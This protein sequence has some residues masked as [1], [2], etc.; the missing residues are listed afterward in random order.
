MKIHNR[1][2]RM[3]SGVAFLIV[4]LM[5]IP[6]TAYAAGS[7]AGEYDTTRSAVSQ[8]AYGED[9]DSASAENQG[10][11]NGKAV[12]ATGTG[13]DAAAGTN[14]GTGAD[15]DTGAGAGSSTDADADS[16]SDAKSTDGAKATDDAKAKSKDAAQKSA[17]GKNASKAENVSA[18]SSDT[19]GNTAGTSS[20]SIANPRVQ[21]GHEDGVEVASWD[22]L[23]NALTDTAISKIYF[24]GDI[25]RTGS[26]D[27]VNDLPK[28]TRNIEINGEG[29]TL[30]FS[31]VNRRGFELGEATPAA[32][33][34]K[35]SN[36]TVKR[37]TTTGYFIQTTVIDTNERQPSPTTGG[38]NIFVDNVSAKGTTN[39]GFVYAGDSEVHFYGKI[40]WIASADITLVMARGTTFE[41]G[42]DIHF[43]TGNRSV[44]FVDSSAQN[45]ADA[46]NTLLY[47]DAKGGAKVNLK[48]AGRQ[49]VNVNFENGTISPIRFAMSGAGTEVRAIGRTTERNEYT[50]VFRAVG[51]SGGFEVTDGA[52]VT[53][54][55]L[56][57]QRAMIQKINV[58]TFNVSGEGT[59]LNLK[60]A[61]GDD[62][63]ATLH[64]YQ[65]GNQIFNVSDHGKL[66]VI[67]IQENGANA[68]AVRMYGSNNKF[69]VSSG[70]QVYIENQGNGIPTNPDDHNGQNKGIEF[71]NGDNQA[72]NI[73]GSNSSVQIIAKNGAAVYGRDNF[74]FTISDGAI[75]IAEGRTKDNNDSYGV[76]AGRNNFNFTMNNPL[77]YDIRN[78]RP[79]GGR[80]IT[81]GNDKGVFTSINSDLA[82]WS[83]TQPLNSDPTK[84]WSLFD[85]I[86]TGTSYKQI[87][88]TNVPT[89]FNTKSFGTVGISAY[90]RMS[91]NNATPNITDILPAT[92]ADKYI[93]A[94]GTIPEGLN[95]AGRP[96]WTDEVHGIFE[97][98]HAD[99]SVS[100]CPASSIQSEMVYG[101][102]KH[103]VLHFAAPDFLQTGDKIKIVSAWRGG[104]D[105]TSPRVHMSTPDKLTNEVASVADATPASPVIITTQKLYA[106]TTEI[107]G[108]ATPD[109]TATPYNKDSGAR[110]YAA[111]TKHGTSTPI[112]I[113]DTALAGNTPFY[114][115]VNPDGTWV[116]EIPDNMK[117]LLRKAG[118]DVIQIVLEDAVKPDNESPRKHLANPLV[119]TPYRDAT[120][121]QATKI[122]TSE[123]RFEIK[124]DDAII[125]RTS[126][127]A[128]IASMNTTDVA[129]V[130]TLN[131]RISETT[132]PADNGK[133]GVKL[134][135]DGGFKAANG[136]DGSYK[137]TFAV[138]SNTPSD[139]DLYQATA[140]L[141]VLDNDNVSE[142][143]D[144]II[145][146]N[147]ITI[148]AMNLQKILAKPSDEEDA[149]LIA[150][151]NARGFL[152][153][154]GPTPKHTLSVGNVNVDT[155][156]AQATAGTY[157]LKFG[158]KDD[159]S[160]KLTVKIHVIEGSYPVFDIHSP[161]ELQ[162]GDSY[163]LGQNNA[164]GTARVTAKE[165]ATD[166]TD[167]STSITSSGAVDTSKKGIYTVEYKATNSDGNTKTEKQV[168]VVNDG[169]YVIISEAGIGY[170]LQAQ[171]YVKNAPVSATDVLNATICLDS[172][173]QAWYIDE[174]GSH[175]TAASVKSVDS[176]YSAGKGAGIYEHVI[177]IENHKLAT[178]TVQAVVVGDGVIVPGKDDHDTEYSLNAHAASVSLYDARF[179][180]SSAAMSTTSLT[181]I[182]G[183]KGFRL[184][185]SAVGVALEIE[186]NGVQNAT[187]TWPVTF[188]IASVPSIKITVNITVGES[189]PPILKVQSPREFTVPTGTAETL[190]A[191]QILAS[192]C[193]VDIEDGV[194][195]EDKITIAAINGQAYGPANTINVSPDAVGIY[196]V[197]YKVTDSHGKSATAIGIIVVNDGR[198]VIDK[199]ILEA[200]PFVTKVTD[201]ITPAGTGA[202][203][204]ELLHKSEAT[205][206]NGTTGKKR[207]EAKYTTVAGTDIGDYKAAV[208]PDGE[209]KITVSGLTLDPEAYTL[210]KPITGKV[211]AGDVLEGGEDKNGHHYDIWANHVILSQASATAIYDGTYEGMTSEAALV[212]VSKAQAAKELG[213]DL[214]AADVKVVS[215]ELAKTGAEVAA[216]RYLVTFAAKDAPNATV[217]IAL[218]V[219]RSIPPYPPQLKVETPIEIAYDKN[220]TNAINVSNYTSTVSALGVIGT[221][222]GIA[223]QDYNVNDGSILNENSPRD[224]GGII[225]DGQHDVVVDGLNSYIVYSY[226]AI[227]TIA[228]GNA[229]PMTISYKI[230]KNGTPV[231]AVYAS[232]PGVYKVDYVVTDNND[233]TDEQSRVI[234]INDGSYTVD[235][236]VIIGAK[237]FLISK[238]AVNTAALNSQ[239]LN[240]S[241][242]TA[243]DHCGNEIHRED[244]GAQ[245]AGLYVSALGG[246][247]DNVGLYHP[248]VKVRGVDKTRT[249]AAR[250]FDEDSVDE[251]KTSDSAITTGTA[252]NGTQYSLLAYS[253]R[254]NIVQAKALLTKAKAQTTPPITNSI[255]G[256]YTT[257]V[258]RNAAVKAYI[259]DKNLSEEGTP[260]LV[261]DGG[262][263]LISDADIAEGL[264]F[265]VTF[266]VREETPDNPANY[267]TVTM[268][269]DNLD[270]PVL[271]VPAIR[272][273]SVGDTLG[274]KQILELGDEA[275]RAPEAHDVQDGNLTSKITIEAIDG[276]P[277]AADNNSI[278]TAKVGL[279]TVSYAVTD[280]DYNTVSKTGFILVNDGIYIVDPPGGDGDPD[281]ATYLIKA[282]NFVKTLDEVKSDF[283]TLT[284][285]PAA[286]QKYASVEAWKITANASQT[287]VTTQA[288]D[289]ADLTFDDAGFTKVA[290]VY[291]PITVQIKNHTDKY[292][293]VTG[294]VLGLEDGDDPDTNEELKV[295]TD[296]NINEK[297]VNTGEFA[298][299]GSPVDGDGSIGVA[300]DGGVTLDPDTY[301]NATTYHLAARDFAVRTS[302]AKAATT[303]QKN[304]NN[305]ILAEAKAE[306]VKLLPTS[307]SRNLKINIVT[308]GG[309]YAGQSAVGG[310]VPG[311]YKILLSVD[312]APDV[313]I[314]LTGYATKG[315]APTITANGTLEFT[316][317]TRTALLTEAYL[318][319]G[320]TASDAEDG[321][322]TSKVKID[323]IK[324]EN[325]KDLGKKVRE[326]QVGVYQVTYGVTD[327]DGNHV[328]TTRAL[329]V[330]DGRFIVGPNDPSTDDEDKIILSAKSFVINHAD[331][332]GTDTEIVTQSLAAAWDYEGKKVPEISLV[333]PIARGENNN[334]HQYGELDGTATAAGIFPITI[335]AVKTASGNEVSRVEK[336]ITARVVSKAIVSTP[337]A[338]SKYQVGANDFS[339]TLT[340]A[341]KI[342][343][344]TYKIDSTSP[345]LTSKAA[346]V[347]LAE[348]EA[349]QI[350]PDYT[351]TNVIVD[352]T[353]FKA[354]LTDD[355]DY[356]TVTF[357]CE[358][359]PN[360]KVTVKVRVTLGN[361]PVITAAGIVA[362]STTALGT[363]IADTV[364][365]KDVSAWDIEDHNLT[366][367]ITYKAFDLQGNAIA[368]I[369]TSVAGI[370]KVAYTVTDEDGNQATATRA[371]V[372][373]D[374]RYAVNPPGA[375]GEGFILGAKDYVI[376]Q[377]E[378]IGTDEEVLTNSYAVAYDAAGK[379]LTNAVGVSKYHDDA[380]TGMSYDDARSGNITSGAYN[381]DVSLYD[382]NDK[383]ITTK[384]ITAYVEN[385]DENGSINPDS[386]Y[387][388]AANNV[389]IPIAAAR[390][391]SSEADAKAMILARS[392]Y[393]VRHLV[394]PEGHTHTPAELDAS[395]AYLGASFTDKIAAN[396][397]SA[398]A[399]GDTWL[400]TLY[401]N[402][403]ETATVQIRVTILDDRPTLTVKSPIIVSLGA[404]YNP[405]W[406]VNA[407]DV[408]DSAK[409]PATKP[410]ITYAPVAGSSNVPLDDIV[411]TADGAYGVATKAGVYLLNYTATDSDGNAVSAKRMVIVDDGNNNYQNADGDE[412]T[413]DSYPGVPTDGAI[414]AAVDPNNPNNPKIHYVIGG[415]DFTIN[416][417]AVESTAADRRAQ[418]LA[419]SEAFA[420]DVK[421]LEANTA[422]GVPVKVNNLKG[423]N[424]TNDYITHTYKPIIQLA[425]SEYVTTQIVAT[426]T[427]KQQGQAP[428]APSLTI[429]TPLVIDAQQTNPA[430]VSEQALLSNVTAVGV[431]A[432]TSALVPDG[433]DE[434]DWP[435]YGATPT[436]NPDGE[437]VAGTFS[438]VD[439]VVY[440]YGAIT[441]SAVDPVNHLGVLN[442]AV[443]NGPIYTSQPGV[444]QVS[445]EA[446]DL[447]GVAVSALGS[448]L[449]SDGS[450]LYEDGYFVGGKS[451]LISKAAVEEAETAALGGATDTV[452]KQILA[453]SGAVG[454]D[455]NGNVMTPKVKNLDGYHAA[456]GV[457]EPVLGI[458]ENTKPE[459]KIHARVYD[460]GGTGF[461][462]NHYSIVGYDYKLN[463]TLAT[464]LSD[465]KDAAVAATGQLGPY[466]GTAYEASVLKD[467]KVQTYLR[468]FGMAASGTAVLVS[469]GG[470]TWNASS[471]PFESYPL[472]FAVKEEP[473]T[474]ITITV[475]F[476]DGEPPVLTVPA[477]KTYTT[478]AIID[479]TQLF[480]N[481]TAYDKEDGST[482]KDKIT[483]A[484][485]TDLA[486][487]RIFAAGETI[488]TTAAGLYSVTYTVMDHDFNQVTKSGLILVNDDTYIVDPPGGDGDDND[489]TYVVK[490][491]GFIKK[492]ADVSDD[493]RGGMTTAQAIA[494]YAGI[495]AWSVST[496]G[497]VTNE[498]AIIQ[499]DGGF[500]VTEG[501]YNIKV[502]IAG[503]TDNA[504][505][506]LGVLHDDTVSDDKD[507]HENGADATYRIGAKDINL[508]YAD[509]VTLSKKSRT[510]YLAEL[511][512]LAKAHAEKI[513][514][515]VVVTDFVVSG[516][517]FDT[518]IQDGDNITPGGVYNITFKMKSPHE[519]VNVTVRINVAQGLSLPILTASGILEE[520]YDAEN[521]HALTD[522]SILDRHVKAYDADDAL[523]GETPKIT[524][525]AFNLSG[526]AIAKIYTSEAGIYTIRYQAKDLDGNKAY[527][528]RTAIIN[529]GTITI[530]TPPSGGNVDRYLVKAAGFI[531]NA[532]D[533]ATAIHAT[534]TDAAILNY[535]Q[536]AAYEI[537]D[538]AVTV[539][540]AAVLN[541]DGF[542]AAEGDY[543]IQIG[544]A[545]IAGQSRNILGVVL[546]A[547][548]NN[549][550]AT[551]TIGAK[552]VELSYVD[553]RAIASEASITSTSALKARAG[554]HGYK[555]VTD[556]S[557]LPA[558]DIVVSA[559]NFKARPGTYDITFA[560]KD[561]PSV[562]VTV[563]ITVL[564][565]NGKPT[566]NAPG[567]IS[568]AA[569]S[570]PAS[571][572]AIA[573][574][575]I[576]K[577]V[578]ATDIE[579]IDLGFDTTGTVT[580]QAFRVSGTAVTPIADNKIYTSE[581]GIYLIR[582]A[583]H[584]HDGN[585]AYATRAAVVNDDTY[586][587]DEPGGAGDGSDSN[588]YFIHADGFIKTLAEVGGAGA[589]LS[590]AQLLAFTKAQA[591]SLSPD[592]V[593]AAVVPA[594]ISAE[595]VT[596]AGNIYTAA[597]GDYNIVLAMAAD[598]TDHMTTVLGVLLDDDAADDNI[599]PDG[600]HDTTSPGAITEG[601]IGAGEDP[602]P[603]SAA[604]KYTLGAKNISLSF[605]DAVNLYKSTTKNAQL[606]A[607][608]EA[609][610]Y[611]F[612]TKLTK[613]SDSEYRIKD[614]NFVNKPGLYTIT[615]EVVSM[616]EVNVTVTIRVAEGGHLPT[617]TAD[618]FISEAAVKTGGRALTDA[619]LLVSVEA[620]DVDD[621]LLGTTPTIRY[622]IKDEFGVNKIDQHIYTSEAGMYAVKYTAT[623]TDGHKA[624]VS[625]P[626]LINNGTFTV[627]P[628]G[629]DGDGTDRNTYFIKA[630]GFI[631]KLSDISGTAISDADLLGANYTDTSAWSL[632]ENGVF[633]RINDN[634]MLAVT[635]RGG[636]TAAEGDYTIGVGINGHT[637][638]TR[639]VLG[640]VTNDDKTDDNIGP[641][642]NPT[643]S[644]ISYTIG[645]NDAT[646]SFASAV[647]IYNSS[648]TVKKEQLA[649]LTKSHGYKL[650]GYLS[651]LVYG[652][653]Y[654]LKDTT[655]Q[656]KPGTYTATFEVVDVPEVN[657]TVVITVEAGANLPVIT[658]SGIVSAAAVVAGTPISDATIRAN[659]TA[660]DVEDA[661]IGKTPT[662]TYQAYNLSGD[663]VNAI[664]TTTAGIYTIK[665]QA[666]D[667]DG[668]IAIASRT[669][670]V[671]DGTVVVVD[672]PAGGED[673]DAY[674]VEAHDFVKQMKDVSAKITATSKNES[675]LSF[676]NAK[677]YAISRGAI[678]PT[679]PAVIADAGFDAVGSTIF[680]PIKIGIAGVA[681]PVRSITGVIF[682]DDAA[683]DNIGPDGDY[684]STD[685][686]VPTEGV[687]DPDN[688]ASAIK[689]TIGANDIELSYIQARQLAADPATHAALKKLAGVHGVKFT[690]SVALLAPTDDI[691]VV[692]T[693]FAPNEGNYHITFA[694]KDEPTVN[695]TVRIMVQPGAGL[696]ELYAPG[697]ISRS[698]VSTGGAALTDDEIKVS[699]NAIDIED[700]NSGFDT[701][702]T[703]TYQAFRVS[704]TSLKPV[705]H[706]YT[707]ESGIYLIR[708]AAHDGDAAAHYAYAT[709]AAIVNDG[710]YLIDEPPFPG[711]PDQ[712]TYF[713]NA[714]GFIEKLAALG[715]AGASVT[716]AKL[717]EL[718]H[719][720][721]YALSPLGVYTDANG[722][723]V[724]S[725]RDG[726]HTAAA[727]EYDIKVSIAG[728]TKSKTVLG[729]ILGDSATDDNIGPD[730]DNDSTDPS[731]PTEGAIEADPTDSAI[732]YTIGASDATIPFASAVAIARGTNAQQKAGLATL[733]KVHGYKFESDLSKLIYNTDYEVVSTDFAALR[734]VYHVTFAV[735]A[736]PSI[737]VTVRVTV[738]SGTSTP[739]I[740]VG[741]IITENAVA[742][743]GAKIGKTALM[744]GVSSY[745]A[746]D[747]SVG[748]EPAITYQAY[749]AD[750]NAID[751]IYTSQ[752]GIYSVKYVATDLDGNTASAIRAVL[753]NDGTYVVDPPGGDGADDGNTYIIHA[754][755]FIKDAEEVK[756][757]IWDN[758]LGVSGTILSY[759]NP[760]AW[761]VTTS[762]ITKADAA[763]AVISDGG[764]HEVEGV[765]QIQVGIQGHT[766]AAKSVLGVV[767]DA[768]GIYDDNLSG[769]DDNSTVGSIPSEEIETDPMDSGITYR[770]GASDVTLSLAS[771]QALAT[772][773]VKN[774]N[775]QIKKLA[776]SYGYK[777]SPALSAEPY[778]V[779]ATSFHAGDSSFRVTP[780]AVHYVTFA[781][782]SQPSINVS[783]KITIATGTNLPV[784]TGGAI[785]SE[786][787]VKPGSQVDL[788]QGVSTYDADDALVGKPNPP[789]TYQAYDA[790]GVSIPAI[791]TS[792]AGVYSV[793][794]IT[795][796]LD[797]NTASTVRGVVINDGN[798]VIDEPGG[799][800]DDGSGNTYVI[801]AAG[802]IKSADDVAAGIAS[803]GKDNA[804]LSYVNP[805][806][807]AMSANGI[808]P[809]NSAIAVISDGGFDS[810]EGAYN[811]TVGLVGH[812][813]AAKTVLGVV[814]DSESVYDDN[815]GGPDNN[816]TVGEV[817]SEDIETDPTGSGITY[818]IGASDVT[819]SL[820]SAQALATGSVKNF[821]TQIKKLAKSYGY[822]FSPALS[823]EPYQVAATSFH[824]GD[825]SFRVTPGVVHYVTFAL[826]S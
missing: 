236:D 753:I 617:I 564:A 354:K 269:I 687:I 138:V 415:H 455:E 135:T 404:L 583:A 101:E 517:S 16:D 704:G 670:I 693:T 48:S 1:F 254:L 32:M 558:D 19:G 587:I 562:N 430:Q 613:L 450:I 632:T 115:T 470:F 174:D 773:S 441:T 662:I 755:G 464:K 255:T 219:G 223:G 595:K 716:D 176:E 352:S 698:A 262:F 612:D 155:H 667:A 171:S 598:H 733:T 720:D 154:E 58:G 45:D 274:T 183:A 179:L 303:S 288:V 589:T 505:A 677:A 99:N 411:T 603:T 277:F 249:I 299:D 275:G 191:A 26:N 325:G 802:F 466:E 327:D 646:I 661:L 619:E 666:T 531:K 402:E 23:K 129:I 31:N 715:G 752:A 740:T 510:D 634:S 495:A 741:G 762:S 656:E 131:A 616:P 355:D 59:E 178:K 322:L 665:Y 213:A 381:I 235:K 349:W 74:D 434:E 210:K 70:G 13:S 456:E 756:T 163:T 541:T 3:K 647:A 641:D 623:D 2:Q 668:N 185:G 492:V 774:F 403:E 405:I 724:V 75:F 41:A 189:T 406:G 568:V 30:D 296:D 658:A 588:T 433:V 212:S 293:E 137:M 199:D 509:A 7:A 113:T 513:T 169:S 357:A 205:V 532:A 471:S 345:E 407:T 297:N 424:R 193:A 141:R 525:Q 118:G 202:A 769:E 707:S 476:G 359:D 316:A 6:Q 335:A 208:S 346:L 527:A 119:D 440:T 817:L 709:R 109:P 409:N 680:R 267:V 503:H 453:K 53:L 261:S 93:R 386:T 596:G 9:A 117:A 91:G 576:K 628:P 673:V 761:A 111:I 286:V 436:A 283:G 749:D 692:S 807:W 39:G 800:G 384:A 535:A 168:V 801:H 717:L 62:N 298:P 35:I 12:A 461:S 105:S 209:Y 791:Y 498:T 561:E 559:M 786:T 465:L 348:A 28:V 537:K 804:I 85:Y 534:S 543:N 279:H 630:N 17:E 10:N 145:A 439:D 429:D 811:I 86:L 54:E 308:D 618:S 560:I 418:V 408:Q 638:I 669:A 247:T 511:T 276:K 552:P 382:E 539:T 737:K 132:N 609:H 676:A 758:G 257:N 73:S 136:A 731:V 225:V 777:F 128:L 706:I 735:K 654:V 611:K 570:N 452:E 114:A 387:A 593:Y 173:A 72:F 540:N 332:T 445:Y 659:V 512:K 51:L 725:D 98:T 419:E 263:N 184:T 196:T 425:S 748:T 390:A 551:Y 317:T 339:V 705:S 393:V 149:S 480:K 389:V 110:V 401:A 251:I 378:V 437:L 14:T 472:T 557:I 388:I 491:A 281:T 770:I 482:I 321:N 400:V 61:G 650:D 252:V 428:Y 50:A 691:N 55:S 323:S 444:Y 353:T 399:G 528:T 768:G 340:D 360:E 350:L 721:A 744:D 818:R 615:F 333:S 66:S 781:L 253:H 694:V 490:A 747:A 529:D 685:P 336:A 487:N 671:N 328:D 808:M 258:I 798:Y 306:A 25:T 226:G 92:N 239:I 567:T 312:A 21:P 813:D 187:G 116:Y 722:S 649:L 544:I 124:A 127:A 788:T 331:V 280:S 602:D 422:T 475:T 486:D 767:T 282:E 713:I 228:S 473:N 521:G 652:D 448:V 653:D 307:V 394:S 514:T 629:G 763:V 414:D 530:V 771:A 460:D 571:A 214:E 71:T 467:A 375:D 134:I 443:I 726:L 309:F 516:S 201:V 204:V 158:E 108:T 159:P 696:P 496:L 139:T 504:R 56:H 246:Y 130:K 165:S 76:I 67:K 809:T 606:T 488:K 194:A 220:A 672:P 816:S 301:A 241:E 599:G 341:K 290:G 627:D 90:S 639:N 52:K 302:E 182:T 697:V 795:T 625:R 237:S 644:S 719:A 824:A 240:R 489:S 329:V 380:S 291:T 789:Y 314:V 442:Y 582:Y 563:P 344:G 211:I 319:T 29:F 305:F 40:D 635:N 377:S 542:G 664:Y 245:G 592:G 675:I 37:A 546:D 20:A 784:I 197:T 426:V 631:K 160:N 604:V 449:I 142:K 150:L 188:R 395:I 524:Y 457:Y 712:N 157:D 573:T 780:G 730:G 265:P 200:H 745:D 797:G 147:N 144:S 42:S 8:K 143:A 714:K 294:I 775:T 64:F 104:A 369:P 140:T 794:Y 153:P 421:D 80:I 370:Y 519:D 754:T 742:T 284:S 637:D 702:A 270:L 324:D 520:V 162:V 68:A 493:I 106:N 548:A 554:A 383:I 423:Y 556:V 351:N 501:A 620:F 651:K 88:S 216:G 446:I 44:L 497:A 502:G 508:T 15:A 34:F 260:M 112:I 198:Y 385:I 790:T 232:E 366:S 278:S 192:A 578:V 175:T 398:F 642:G 300:T 318:K 718:A 420:Y 500:A 392:G 678:T 373:N 778:Q 810:I 229:A 412:I 814:T 79:G 146:A 347:A 416:A 515:D 391:I 46:A 757:D 553:A 292:K 264:H 120:F 367:V 803:L 413:P 783:V 310:G 575:V 230:Y 764:F 728:H 708:Y 760:H 259:R 703:I 107:R 203:R 792:E 610:G 782:G 151:A 49:V 60:S 266:K 397:Q 195:I 33:T 166:N 342:V 812:T 172:K 700:E 727:G 125:G 657:V 684:D 362:V 447:C 585:Y 148:T 268:Y 572:S 372:V 361:I 338:L 248:I 736:I 621:A 820:A 43:D 701:D 84:S 374:G 177:Q 233:R 244:Q 121:K 287:A 242:A 674:I 793:K 614:T 643:G 82:V 584:D 417:A 566:L 102:D 605:A 36:L 463:S 600:D 103:G 577:D 396:G 126:A 18:S 207:V 164:A 234:I 468:D 536:A 458:K 459:A 738:E 474:R 579:D 65:V 77:Y 376:Q 356:Y 690:T 180:V 732:K 83:H 723:L 772:G 22:E 343:G 823:A 569:V 799:P 272:T 483:I 765:Y 365:R 271:T 648:N 250:V 779:A 11:E 711:D 597:E 590:N 485:I 506:I 622:E 63:D 95:I 550:D 819:L 522:S 683:D 689:H 608:A 645:A 633:A 161:L 565:G 38:W 451:F 518:V 330:N 89:E 469:D 243:F 289:A 152:K 479:D 87:S 640:I 295:R 699:V 785:I 484:A 215:T 586:L 358:G 549:S 454:W 477:M 217:T 368:A 746:D 806:A 607:L 815:E 379:D 805:S 81:T 821:N 427:T 555:F 94:I 686:T 776:K 363:P 533:V 636:F 523:I 206:Y 224:N 364:L 133:Y 547:G 695:V 581:P 626:V 826:G 186:N 601:G 96:L 432:T 750:G 47:V 729:V 759:T 478:G 326:N 100:A 681:N 313:A 438:I 238:G 499:N 218:K 69:N 320:V 734:G 688:T 273:V 796:D 825:S 526:E 660:Y 682:D 78:T 710:T 739:T 231:N 311:T 57:S 481:V 679:L 227:T 123:Y 167:I 410:S 594:I 743:G 580:H 315:K 337:G 27:A 334:G 24:T 507:A 574:N 190:S 655:L 4:L 97:I 538:G 822:K 156:N 285:S 371:A 624:S 431:V 545:G 494:S 462:G 256:A 751:G 663:A 5:L 181:A 766:D 591:Y 435:W 787:A 122:T 170:I 304:F 221:R 222:A